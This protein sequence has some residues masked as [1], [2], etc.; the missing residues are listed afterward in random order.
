[1]VNISLLMLPCWTADQWL[2]K[3]FPLNFD[4]GREEGLIDI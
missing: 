2:G 3:F 1:M 4:D